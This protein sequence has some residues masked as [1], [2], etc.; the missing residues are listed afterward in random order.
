MSGSVIIPIVDIQLNEALR[1]VPSIE[2][3]RDL[4][5]L[6]PDGVGTIHQ[7]KPEIWVG[8]CVE[9]HLVRLLIPLSRLLITINTDLK[10]ISSAQ[11]EPDKNVIQTKVAQTT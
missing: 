9:M 5:E 10:C 6:C 4:I 2:P 3:H 7:V 8:S 1:V 11:T